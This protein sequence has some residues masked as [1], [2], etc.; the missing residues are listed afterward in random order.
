MRRHVIW[1]D[2]GLG[3]DDPAR[4]AH[5]IIADVDQ[6]L[7]QHLAGDDCQ[8]NLFMALLA[9]LAKKTCLWL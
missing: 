6:C 7:A 1:P 9:T 5:T 3:L 4:P 2:I 8:K